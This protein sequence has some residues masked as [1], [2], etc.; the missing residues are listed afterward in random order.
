M[1]DRAR[2]L[3][4]R[5][6]PGPQRERELRRLRALPRCHAEPA[7]RAVSAAAQRSVSGAAGPAGSSSN[8]GTHASLARTAA[9]VSKS[10]ASVTMSADGSPSALVARHSGGSAI[11]SSR[12]RSASAPASTGRHLAKY[13]LEATARPSAAA[14][15]TR[16][17]ATGLS[18]VTPA[19]VYR[20]SGRPGL[21]RPGAGDASLGDAGQ[22][23]TAS[24]KVRRQRRQRRQVV[25]AAG[26][27][28]ALSTSVR[29]AQGPEQGKRRG[30]IE[31]EDRHLPRRQSGAAR[32][33]GAGRA[34]RRIAKDRHCRR[35]ESFAK[36]AAELGASVISAMSAAGPGR[37]TDRPA[38]RGGEPERHFVL[39][40][41]ADDIGSWLAELG[42]RVGQQSGRGGERVRP[43]LPAARCL[44]AATRAGAG[45]SE[46][47]AHRLST[48][49]AQIP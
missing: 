10:S 41:L 5:V 43:R 39:G 46:S 44:L 18:R 11:V 14:P 8:P 47:S 16:A 31:A 27:H 40:R 24:R 12:A 49:W 2:R 20:A 35:A 7:V 36:P 19:P 9:S 48:P 38:G 30:G 33:R 22:Y 6:L 15:R 4:R 45:R 13:A 1:R 32:A 23:A 3:L 29:A 26:Q 37:P 17:S 42:D 28:R 21:D 25:H 34:S